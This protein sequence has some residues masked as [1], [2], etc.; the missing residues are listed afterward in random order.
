MPLLALAVLSY[1][2]GLV[3]GFS[4]LGGVART[5]LAVACAAG[6]IVAAFALGTRAAAACALAL[7][8]LLVAEATRRH[9]RACAAAVVASH[10]PHRLVLERDAS[11]AAVV[12][13]RV[14]AGPCEVPAT[15][16][17][18]RGDAPAGAVVLATGEAQP[19]PRGVVLASARLRTLR[20]PATLDRLRAR[21]TRAVDRIFRDDAPLARALLLADMR[22]IDPAL[23]DRWGASGLVHMLSVSGLHVGLLAGVVLL[24]LRAARLPP[25]AAELVGLAVV[26][27]YVIGIGAPP[28]AVRAAAML[29]AGAASRVLQRPTSPWA[30]LAL[31]ALHPVLRPRVAVDLGW[32]LSVV[33]I[34]ALAGAGALTDRIAGDRIVG[35]R[36]TLLAGAVTSTLATIVTLPFTAPVFGRASTVAPLTNLAAAP[37]M[38]AAQPVLF[39]AFA[40][41]PSS[42]LARLAADAVHPLLVALDRVAAV[43]AAVPFATVPVPATAGAVAMLAVIAGGTLAACLLDR[44]V[45]GWLPAAGAAALVPW[46]GAAPGRG[47]AELHVIDVGQ[48]DAVALRSGRGRWVL[49]DAGR[50]WQGGDAGRATVVP[51]LRR[52]GGELRA[53]VM[54]HAHAD[55]VGGL[56]SVVRALRPALFFDPAFVTPGGP[57]R[58]ALRVA[59]AT[60]TRWRRVHPGD[61]LVVDDLVLT[62]LA[63]DSAW[64]RGLDDPNDASTVAV[65]RVGSVRFLLTGDAERAEEAWLLARGVS[66][67][68]TVLKVAHHGSSTSSTDAWLDAV[69]PRVALVSVG[70][71]NRY[72]HPSAERM[73]ALA[74]RGAR[75]LRT[76]RL[77]SIVLRTDGRRLVVDADGDEWDVPLDSPPS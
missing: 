6:A 49:V 1:V 21:S 44:P 8:G 35:W 69:Q 60:G 2:V 57:Y 19:V 5:A 47:W 36:R 66:L 20:A 40:L 38:A 71:L 24:A 34:V 41:A 25:V 45:H 64:A 61:S 53:V 58:A 50:S 26:G 75:V 23:R 70:A 9:E 32:Q 3:G 43:G 39:L 31:G 27:A 51:Y 56:A 14:L 33:G 11:P 67:K 30:V 4:S 7:A 18:A 68:A 15:L 73:R 17:V 62:F 59:R 54:T 72:G 29:G 48:G 16:F 77:G 12:R 13:A 65:A 42:A 22:T 74:A 63:P 76:D 28:P 46:L 10:G 37:L 55:H 52:R